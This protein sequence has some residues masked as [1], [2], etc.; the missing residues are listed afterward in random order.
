[1]VV[2][3]RRGRE[4][5]LRGVAA[6]LG[7]VRTVLG[8]VQRRRLQLVIGRLYL[9]QVLAVL[10]VR[11]A[12]PGLGLPFAGFSFGGGTTAAAGLLGAAAE[13]VAME[14]GSHRSGST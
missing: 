3:G 13:L 4:R 6:A 1:M 8:R 14:I 11:V 12:L 2:A 5:V 10:G 9:Q 7:R